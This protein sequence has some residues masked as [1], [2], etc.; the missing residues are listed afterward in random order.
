MTKLIFVTHP[1]VIVDPNKHPDEWQLSDEGLKEVERLLQKEFWREIKKIYSSTALK[2][3]S[4]AKLAAQKYNI[5]IQKVNELNE[6]NRDSTGFLSQEKY[7]SAIEDFY[8]HPSD[9]YK[10]WETAYEATERI[11][12]CID[13]IFAD[14][15]DELIVIVG[16]GIIGSCLSCFIKGID[17][18]FNEDNDISSSLI[19]IHWRNKKII[20][21]WQRY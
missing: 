15:P 20:N 1:S 3:F 14:Q 19:E 6:I 11:K 12:K 9:S 10:G 17:P 4:V 21:D 2:A 5:N 7:N 18:A 13:D 16:H 8:I